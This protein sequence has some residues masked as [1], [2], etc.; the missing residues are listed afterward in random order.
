MKTARHRDGLPESTTER[1]GLLFGVDRHDGTLIDGKGA[2][3][4]PYSVVQKGD[5]GY[6]K[7]FAG[8]ADATPPNGDDGEGWDA[9]LGS[10]HASDRVYVVTQ[11]NAHNGA[12]DEQKGMFGFTDAAA[13]EEHYRAHTAP[14]MFGRIGGLGLDAF[15]GQLRAHRE[16]GAKVFRTET[17]EDFAELQALEAIEK[18]FAP[19]DEEEPESE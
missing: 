8:E 16:S 4:R 2:D 13:A 3:G 17:E 1:H 6:V 5:Y 11:K 12:Y 10:H 15:H 14:S 19:D 9:Y 7:G 18:G